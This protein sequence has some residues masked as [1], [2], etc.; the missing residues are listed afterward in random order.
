MKLLKEIA[1]NESYSIRKASKNLNIPE[2][3]VKDIQLRLE[4][5][6]YIERIKDEGGCNCGC[7]STSCYACSSKQSYNLIKLTEKGINALQIA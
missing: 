2:E 1:K 5:L 4:N 3:M 7:T 6:G